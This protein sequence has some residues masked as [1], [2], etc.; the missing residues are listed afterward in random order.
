MKA[1]LKACYTC[2]IRKVRCGGPTPVPGAKDGLPS[3]CANCRRLEFQCQWKPPEIGESYVPP[4]KRRR[5]IGQ[6]RPRSLAKTSKSPSVA[7]SPN[8]ESVANDKCSA[9]DIPLSQGVQERPLD[10]DGCDPSQPFSPSVYQTGA[11]ELDFKFESEC[12]AFNLTGEGLDDFFPF[13]NTDTSLLNLSDPLAVISTSTWQPNNDADRIIRPGFQSQSTGDVPSVIN[14][15]NRHLIQHYLEVMK[16]YS[17]VDDRPK[18][19]N[20]LF[21]SAFTQSLTFPPLLYAILA[22]SASHLSIKDPL[23]FEQ[24]NK[25]NK[26]AEETFH[27]HKNL[28]GTDIASLLGALFV[29]IKQVHVM[30]GCVDDFFDLIAA[31]VDIVSTNAGEKALADPNSLVRRIVLRLA[32]LDSRA[33]C[34]GLGGGQLVRLLRQSPALSS[35]FNFHASDSSTPSYSAA[36]NLLRADILR[37][38]IGELDTRLQEQL[39]AEFLTGPPIRMDYVKSLYDD[40]Q[41]E[42]DR[43]DHE[44]LYSCKGLEPNHAMGEVLESA[45]YNYYAVSSALHSALL[46]LYWVYPLPCV[47]THTS[48][49]KILQYQLKIQ[50]DPS[51]ANTPTSILP[52]SLFLAGLSTTDPIHRDWVLRSLKEGEQWGL[53]IRKTRKL[54]D[55]VF[56]MQVAGQKVDVRHVMDQVTGKFFI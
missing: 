30:G 10:K 52:S 7:N 25:F 41:R 23:C 45:Q 19:S 44:A 53:Y 8:P 5:A 51:R 32:L 11:F 48:V 17:K 27:E 42:L 50:Q 49:S 39:Q 56:K 38:R 28:Q 54:L 3:K 16:G 14:D 36:M 40:I 2:R 33:T 46:Y 55:A 15:D 29:R 21:I 12:L 13:S 20:N 47:N 22:F 6:R 24:A 4:P 1:T 31:A 34:F 35:V 9:S 18:E 37:N 26:L 43:C